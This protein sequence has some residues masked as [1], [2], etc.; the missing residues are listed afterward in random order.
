MADVT[1]KMQPNYDWQFFT[2]I[3]ILILN[4]LLWNWVLSW[5]EKEGRCVGITLFYVALDNMPTRP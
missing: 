1:L 5:K 2:L 4:I 3:L